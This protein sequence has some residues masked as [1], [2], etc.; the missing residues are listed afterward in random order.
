MRRKLSVLPALFFVLSLTPG[1]AA[2]HDGHAHGMEPI[3]GTVAHIE[4]DRLDVADP[5]G[6][7]VS[8]TLTSATTYFRGTTEAKKADLKAGLRVAVETAHGKSG[9]EAKVVRI[10]ASEEVVWTC[11]MH[12]EVKSA[13]PGKCPKCGM[14]LEKKKA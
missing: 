8:V 10:G 11:P 3:L 4:G 12:P 2:A 14:F 1:L 13:G 5:D 7:T 9:L 6:K